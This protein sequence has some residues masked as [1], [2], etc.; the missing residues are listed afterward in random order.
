MLT[1]GSSIVLPFQPKPQSK[2]NGRLGFAQACDAW[3]KPLLADPQFTDGEIRVCVAIYLGFN[4]NHYQ[5]TGQLLSWPT[6]RALEDQTTKSEDTIWRTTKK[7]EQ[8]GKLQP[9]RRGFDPKTGHRLPNKYLAP[10]T[11]HPCGVATPQ[12]HPAPE[13][14]DS[15]SRLDDSKRGLSIE[16]REDSEWV[17][18]DS[19]RWDLIE[20]FGRQAT[21]RQF[22]RFGRAGG[23]Y[24]L[25][26]DLQKIEAAAAA[27]GGS[28]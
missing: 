12:S 26:A 18:Y 15:M 28:Q 23:A 8:L 9:L 17:K 3:L 1:A 21:G 13:R 24:F 7:L 5:E 22:P 2:F 19:P 20:R 27:N 6:W 4:S 25:K 10:S 11:P 16:A 14:E